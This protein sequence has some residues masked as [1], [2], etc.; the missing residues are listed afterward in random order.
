MSILNVGK[1]LELPPSYIIMHMLTLERDLSWTSVP[2]ASQHFLPPFHG[3]YPPALF[4]E[5][6]SALTQQLM[7]YV[8][9]APYPTAG[10]QR[11]A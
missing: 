8:G 11:V 2:L 1:P 7:W 3:N 9:E 4:L 6:H 10:V 5:S